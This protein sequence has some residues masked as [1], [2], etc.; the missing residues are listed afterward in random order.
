MYSDLPR[1]KSIIWFVLLGAVFSF[2]EIFVQVPANCEEECGAVFI[3]MGLAMLTRFCI[4]SSFSLSYI[5]MGEFYPASITELAMGTMGLISSSGN[6]LGIILFTDTQELSINPYLLIGLILAFVGVVLFKAPET[7][8]N[9][10]KDQIQE[11]QELEARL[12]H[13]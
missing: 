10:P 11:V 2:V 1:K 3:E 8:G 12:K 4:V 9:E 6:F 7:I 5:M 13:E